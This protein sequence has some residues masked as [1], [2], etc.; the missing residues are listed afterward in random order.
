MTNNSRI[1]SR[2]HKYISGTGQ[3]GR[4]RGEV[5]AETVG[6]GAEGGGAARRTAGLGAALRSE[7]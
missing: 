5:Q 6:A 1:N 3:A 7:P 2:I 4:D